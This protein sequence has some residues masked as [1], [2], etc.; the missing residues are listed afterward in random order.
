M[1]KHAR[2]SPSS[3]DRWTTCTAS[4][5]AQDGIPNTNSDAS[6]MGTVCHQIA[7]E[8]LL[9]EFKSPFD[10]VGREFVFYYLAETERDETDWAEDITDLV[11]NLMGKPEAV[12]AVTDDMA[13]AVATGV[14]YV[15]EQHELLGGKLFV[16][17]R[18]PVGQFTGEDDAEGS[19]DVILLGS[20]WISTFDFKFGRKRVNAS[21]LIS[22]Q[23]LDFITG[24]MQPEKRG[25][26]LQMGCYSLGAV[27]KH[28]L[29]GE[30][31]TVTMTIVQPFIDHTDSYTCTIE[32]LR[33]TERF[34]AAKAEE[35][36]TNPRFVPSF[37]ACFFCRAKGTC[38]AQADKALSGVFDM[39]DDNSGVPKQPGVPSLGSQ[40]ALVPFI[41]QWTKD[42][43]AA[44]ETALNNGE[45]VVRDDGLAYKLVEGKNGPRQWVDATEAETKLKESGLAHE[46][47]YSYSLISPTQAEKLAVK[48][49]KGPDPLLT[50]E[51]WE[52]LQPLV[53]QSKGK[54]QVTLET[55]PRPAITAADGF[56]E[57]PTH[58]ETE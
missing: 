19:A 37:E 51:Q 33:A 8:C 11:W 3:A 44:V 53:K 7:E 38:N 12:I 41:E 21:R 34:L 29:F 49:K 5:A 6:R 54:P 24:A 4:P 23:R 50:Q 10:Y 47:R 15:K 30:V 55:D 48:K 42:V 20:D 22:P 46:V 27:Y 28:D 9:D 39:L 1:A 35:S 43:N 52:S 45:P 25:P 26:N 13:A 2:L 16:E 56:E 58:G 17:Q 40:Y 14:A 18:V 57:V 32:E 36:R 31:K